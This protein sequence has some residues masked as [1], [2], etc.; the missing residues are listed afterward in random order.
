MIRS[1]S[2]DGHEIGLHA[3]D[4]HGWQ[5]H[6]ATMEAGAIRDVLRRGMTGSATSPANRR[7][8]RRFP[9]GNARRRFWKKK[10]GCP[11]STTA[12]AGAGVFLPGGGRPAL[13]QPQVPVTL[14][15]YDEAIGR[16]GSTAE[17]FN[18]H[19]LSLIETRTASMS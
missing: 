13:T 10:A 2:G 8:V 11:L 19:I 1:A 6:I 4:H 16:T 9:P 17:N 15:T 18:D 3:W 14:P 12:T 7:P 5:A